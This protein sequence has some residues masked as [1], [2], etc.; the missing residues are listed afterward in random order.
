MEPFV[1]LL[2]LFGALFAM[3]V[4]RLMGARAAEILTTSLMGLAA[5]YAWILFFRV[6]LGGQSETIQLFTWIASG[7][8]SS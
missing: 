1:V 7:D 3:P 4:G 5:L 8:F 6:A 2:P